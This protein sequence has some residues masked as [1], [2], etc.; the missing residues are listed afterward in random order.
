MEALVQRCCGLDVHQRSI[1]ACIMRQGY[2]RQVRTFET[3]TS[4]LLLLK[5][6]LLAERITHLAMESAGVYWKPVFNVLDGHFTLLLV[7]TRHIKHV[8]GRKTDVMDAEWICQLLRAGL[9][10]GS[11]V[12]PSG[13]GSTRRN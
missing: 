6:W 9:L 10:K 8:P 11:F 12:P 3:T 1:T 13:R 2:P 7:K 5:E 4:A